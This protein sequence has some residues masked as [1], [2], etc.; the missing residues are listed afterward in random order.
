MVYDY[1]NLSR[2]YKD[3][4]YYSYEDCKQADLVWPLC[5]IIIDRRLIVE[6]NRYIKAR[7]QE[8]QNTATLAR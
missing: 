7:F 8:Q 3:I 6:I 2:N 1:L 4:V 5:I